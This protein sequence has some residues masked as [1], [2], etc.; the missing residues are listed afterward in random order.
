MFD[1][2]KPWPLG[3]NRRTWPIF[4]AA[5]VAIIAVLSTIDVA[6][7]RGAIGWPDEWRAPFFMIT[8]YGLSDWVLIPSLAILILSALLRLP[9]KE[10]WRRAMGEV[11]L[12]SG[13]FFVGVG[14][15]GLL[16]N[17]AKRL[18]GRGRPVE[19]ENAGAFSFKPVINDW[20]YQSFPSG[21]S[22]TAMA[23]AFVIGFLWPRALMPF[24]VIAIVV[25]ISRVPVGAHYPTDVFAGLV[26]GMLGTYLVR[27]IFAS[28]GWL[29]EKRDDG[30]I[31]R[32]P[33]TALPKLFQRASA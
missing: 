6:A 1:I 24:V 2:S 20:T 22:A 16:T 11:A 25:G 3:L 23:L 15:P 28:R 31:Y 18:V 27:N 7:S 14:A 9:L 4:L 8:D 26:V 33:L 5:V 17:I 30:R 10:L 19:F 21:H 13:F 12:L 32:K 29:F